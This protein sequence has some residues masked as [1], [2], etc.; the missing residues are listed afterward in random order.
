MRT[1]SFFGLVFLFFISSAWCP[2]E[3]SSDL[4]VGNKQGN[5]GTTVSIPIDFTSDDGGCHIQFDL[6]YDASVLT[7]LSPTG[8]SA[9]ADHVVDANVISP[10]HLRFVVY[11]FSNAQMGSGRLQDA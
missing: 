10:G 11:S 9:S 1:K 4:I 6:S 8:G 3:A 2:V 7:P 5:C